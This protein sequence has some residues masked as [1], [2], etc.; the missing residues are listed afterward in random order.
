MKASILIVSI[1]FALAAC[2]RYPSRPPDAE[3]EAYFNE[4]EHDWVRLPPTQRRVLLS[5]VIADDFVGF[6]P[7][8]HMR[9]KAGAIAF[10]SSPNSGP[11]ERLDY[12]RY[13]HFGDIVVV[14][15]QATAARISGGMPVRRIFMHL[16]TFRYGKWWVISSEDVEHI[17]ST[18]RQPDSSAH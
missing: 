7:D 13:G 16:W 4:V 15:G 2:F 8:G 18:A 9:N 12:L 1:A 3:N 10:Y 11:P 14:H 6:T 5:R 17:S